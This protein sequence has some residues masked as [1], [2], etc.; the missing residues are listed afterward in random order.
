MF[1]PRRRRAEKNSD[2]RSLYL[3]R[4]QSVATTKHLHSQRKS[5]LFQPTHKHRKHIANKPNLNYTSTTTW[6]MHS[7]TKRPISVNYTAKGQ[8]HARSA[9][10]A[11]CFLARQHMSAYGLT[12]SA[13]I[14][15]RMRQHE[16]VVRRKKGKSA[17]GGV[18][19]E[20]L[21]ERLGNFAANIDLLLAK[22]LEIE[23]ISANE[24]YKAELKL[25]RKRYYRLDSKARPAP[26]RVQFTIVKGSGKVLLSQTSPRPTAENNDKTL[27]LAGNHMLISYSPNG[28]KVFTEEYVYIAV[29]ASGELVLSFQCVFGRDKSNVGDGLK[30]MQKNAGKVVAKVIDKQS[31]EEDSIEEMLRK[32]NF[33]T[34]ANWTKKYDRNHS[35]DYKMRKK[36][37]CASK[38]EMERKELQRKFVFSRRYEIKQLYTQILS[39]FLAGLNNHKARARTWTSLVLFLRLAKY[40]LRSFYVL[41]Y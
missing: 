23:D 2:A 6:R 39:K 21:K 13:E 26:L 18:S 32:N 34:S 12:E 9:S 4:A 28:N 19:Y 37:V 38:E 25:I 27:Y 35:V 29:E 1:G 31:V 11:S 16:D 15:R 3:N 20:E 36:R 17:S 7:T 30:T 41:F 10:L 8:H 5:L 22:E 14:R 40:L 24:L 33:N